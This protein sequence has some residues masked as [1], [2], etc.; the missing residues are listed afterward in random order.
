MAYPYKIKKI[1][2][3]K[4]IIDNGEVDLSLV[5]E[6]K[7][8]DWVLVKDNLAVTTISEEDA[9]N[10]IELLDKARKAGGSNVC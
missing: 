4:A 2:G 1:K 7:I 3:A 9:L 8:G 6:I 5:N 10:M